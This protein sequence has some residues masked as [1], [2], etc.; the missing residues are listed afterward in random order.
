[1][2]K[3]WVLCV[4]G[5]SY[6]CR[7]YFGLGGGG[8]GG[9]GGGGQSRWLGRSSTLDNCATGSTECEMVTKMARSRVRSAKREGRGRWY[10]YNGGMGG[11]WWQLAVV[12]VR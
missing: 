1:M 6:L 8:G 11:E 4:C 12:E 9:E 5:E 10:K 2:S 7:F 3:S